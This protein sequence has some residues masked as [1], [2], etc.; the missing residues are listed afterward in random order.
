MKKL[1]ALSLLC[2][3]ILTPVPAFAQSTYQCSDT[4]TS[5]CA[6]APVPGLNLDESGKPVQP[7]PQGVATFLNNLYIFAIGI[8][9]ILAVG[10]IIYGG[11]KYALS[12]VPSAKG[13]GKRQ[14]TQALFG[15]V[16]VLAPALVFTIINPE[17]L[18][19]NVNFEA[20]QTSWGTYGGT[21]NPV[22]GTAAA[23]PSPNG[24]YTESVQALQDQC[25]A[26][27][28][29][30]RITGPSTSPTVTCDPAPI[31]P[32]PGTKVTVDACYSQ[33]G[34]AGSPLPTTKTC[35]TASASEKGNKANCLDL[36]DQPGICVW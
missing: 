36:S 21:T 2:A 26:A 17:I 10:M 31:P 13:D 5:F 27:G 30:P 33:G 15:L 20:L 9:V 32:A 28:G 1:G 12:Q 34:G 3:T 35:A 18:K 8:A 25:R 14:I 23:T 29:V 4:D 24:G 7:S 22:G 6:L 11:V 16:L 19:L